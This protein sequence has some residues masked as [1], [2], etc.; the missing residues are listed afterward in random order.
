MAMSE[1]DCEVEFLQLFAGCN[2][3]PNAA[4]FDVVSHDDTQGVLAYGSHNSVVLRDGE[5]FKLVAQLAAHTQ[6]VNCVKWV[7]H[8]AT[9]F[10]LLLSGSTDNTAIVWSP[11]QSQSQSQSSWSVANKLS[12]HTAAI[13]TVDSIW[14]DSS[15]LSLLVFTGSSDNSVK[16]WRV[17]VG[18]DAQELLQ[19]I[20]YGAGLPL[21][22]AATTLVDSTP[23]LAVGTDDTK[24]RLYALQLHH[25]S[26]QPSFVEMSVIPGHQDWVRS[27]SFAYVNTATDT[28]ELM[29][30]SSS[31]D[32]Y[33]RV[34]KIRH[35]TR[36]AAPTTDTDA[37]RT[38]SKDA[39]TSSSPPSS[40]PPSTP[41]ASAALSFMENVQRGFER[42]FVVHDVANPTKEN[43]KYTVTLEA[44]LMGHDNW[45]YSVNWHP[46]INGFQP[47]I[48]LSA[49]MDRTLIVWTPDV[50]SGIWID[51]ARVGESGGTH[52]QGFFG[53]LFHPAG[54]SIVAHG[55][56]GS[57]HRWNTAANYQ[58]KTAQTQGNQIKFDSNALVS[59][60]WQPTVGIT[61]HFGSVRD[62]AWDPSSSYL[63]SASDDQTVRTYACCDGSGASDPQWH[64]VGRPQIHGYD[65]RCI[66]L[67]S[68]LKYC[69]GADEKI[70]RVFEAPE[71]FCDAIV[72]LTTTRREVLSSGGQK[73]ALGA[74][75]P[76]L[77]LSNKA[78]FEEDL[79]NTK[80]IDDKT[81]TGGYHDS[82]GVVFPF[83]R[84]TLTEPPLEEV[85]IQNT[86][87]PE[88]H[89]LYGHGF[90]LISLATTH[91][92]DVLFSACKASVSEHASIRVWD[93][94]TNREINALEGHKL[95]V[96]RI[97][98]SP[99]D[100]WVASA[101]R[102]RQLCIYR[103]LDD[104]AKGY[105]NHQTISKAHDRIIWDLDFSQDGKFLASGARDKM[106][107]FWGLDESGQWGQVAELGKLHES[108]T[109]LAWAPPWV[110]PQ[111]GYGLVVGFDDGRIEIYAS[112]DSTLSFK[113]V[114]NLSPSLHHS[115][116]VRRL[117][118]RGRH[119]EDDTK[120]IA[121]LASCGA[122]C[123]VRI[124]S[125]GMIETEA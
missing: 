112:A 88:T 6:R 60:A 3:S 80:P 12:G 64:E 15:C 124:F 102:D 89:K 30:A 40:T 116:T 14:E 27:L 36:D 84:T 13:T 54:S 35:D 8:C 119:G 57:I 39:P 123:S 25:T 117:G 114:A 94:A 56:H 91:A 67:V 18:Q 106:V 74:S 120:S 4:D 16:I 19:T 101:S 96:T 87:W 81:S 113:R 110:C 51:A 7:P 109:S 118:W 46:Q 108:V 71:A 78:V 85:L 63:M 28:K 125:V 97:R 37:D 79:E 83:V 32:M 34:W 92:G 47:P 105:G 21:S 95:T 104:D 48:L 61:G 55:F 59:A 10:G 90:E 29:L 42:S 107:K 73:Q 103:R 43:S 45:V 99:N 2:R 23:L 44:L 41:S 1:N 100:E 11:D 72:T 53:A 66:A 69:S 49:S 98:C 86:L 26:S 33:V 111:G 76:S 93:L 65:M 9:S 22:I 17:T 20:S 5:T 52:I 50:E 75:I 24:I 68:P 58:D 77:G 70:T 38:T 121:Q 115:A 31:Q 62:M 82:D 122:D